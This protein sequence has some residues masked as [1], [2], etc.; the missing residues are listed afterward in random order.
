M[1][2]VVWSIV[3]LVSLILGS[4]PPLGAAS[5][6]PISVQLVVSP[7][8]IQTGSS[9]HAVVLISN[10]GSEAIKTRACSVHGLVGVGLTSAREDGAP[11]KAVSECQKKYRLPTGLTR[12]VVTV[13]AIYTSCGSSTRACTAAHK[14][15]PLPPGVYRVA[16]FN[17][18]LPKSVPMVKSLPV[19]LT[20]P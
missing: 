7:T 14:P 13:V 12:L 8:R 5:L 2:R 15:P 1:R 16:T 3:V 17:F 6:T 18:G 19:T 9:F 10:G 20:S 11:L 4:A